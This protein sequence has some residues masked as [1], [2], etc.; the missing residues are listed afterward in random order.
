MARLLRAARPWT[1]AVDT[2]T[3][4]TRYVSVACTVVDERAGTADDTRALAERYL[5]P[6]AGDRYLTFAAENLA[7]ESVFVLR[8][9]HHWRSADLTPG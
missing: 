6:G 3:P 1:L 5:P 2:V 9:P 7:S 8:R 4:R